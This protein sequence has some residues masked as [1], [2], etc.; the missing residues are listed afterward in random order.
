MKGLN[1]KC[2]A[3]SRFCK[4]YGSCKWHTSAAYFVLKMNVKT[5]LTR[6]NVRALMCIQAVRK[7][8]SYLGKRVVKRDYESPEP[9]HVAMTF[10][11]SLIKV[12]MF[13]SLCINPEMLLESEIE[14]V[15]PKKY[16]GLTFY[17][18]S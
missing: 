2:Q 5:L 6:N 10:V 9:H 3:R 14:I 18:W 17:Q 11:F 12:I 1:I 4:G 13:D 7:S 16:N 8:V 15:N